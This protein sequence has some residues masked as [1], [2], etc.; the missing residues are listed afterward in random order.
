MVSE[1]LKPFLLQ[2]GTV[3]EERYEVREAIACGGFGTTYKVW[4]MDHQVLLAMKEFFPQDISSRMPDGTIVPTSQEY[5]EAFEHGALRFTEEAEMLY[6]LGGLP[7]NGI[8][9]IVKLTDYFRAYG[10]RYYVMDYIDGSSLYAIAR[11]N[12][13]GMPWK[14]VLYYAGEL[15]DTLEELHTKHDLF[16]R[17]I[18][19]ENVMVTKD[20]YPMLIDFGNARN[21]SARSGHTVNLK[22]A[23]A[24]PE[25]YL[26]K[27]EQG[28][29]TDVYSLAATMYYLLTG[30]YVPD[31]LERAN[32]DQYGFT[33]LHE[34]K[35]E[36]PREISDALNHALEYDVM[37][38]TQSMK[39]FKKE[40][41]VEKFLETPMPSGGGGE[42]PVLKKVSGETQI[43]EVALKP[44]RTTILGRSG[45]ADVQASG[46][47]TISRSHCSIRYHSEEKAFYL[48]DISQNGTYVDGKCIPSD[49]ELRVPVGTHIILGKY[50]C[51]FEL[52]VKYE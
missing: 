36:I 19:P 52:G 43:Q 18:S 35:P 10:T 29:F 5:R 21:V 14:E 4:D 6:K 8:D 44:G 47:P 1:K 41:G 15:C 26:T 27:G 31:A 30:Q 28:A 2:D 49:T 48:K 25:Q 17:D 50:I 23:Y 39:Q 33:P 37:H 45:K 7:R 42:I 13:K 46:N 20:R 9:R 34:L 38:R 22:V 3:L 12:P 16:H 51:E 32:R 24:P 11:R 40:L